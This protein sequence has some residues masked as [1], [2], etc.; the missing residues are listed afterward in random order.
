[1]Q[2]ARHAG[3]AG[4]AA[5]AGQAQYQQAQQQQQGGIG[6]GRSGYLGVLVSGRQWRVCIHYDKKAHGLGTFSTKE[7]RVRHCSDWSTG[8]N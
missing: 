1:V 7:V 2:Q 4:H 5:Q 6:I 3:Q 8:P